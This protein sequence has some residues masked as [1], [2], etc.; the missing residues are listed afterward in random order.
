M[1]K[2][3]KYFH[4]NKTTSFEV[5]YEKMLKNILKMKKKISSLMKK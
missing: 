1:T 2:Y 4:T 5:I 3:A